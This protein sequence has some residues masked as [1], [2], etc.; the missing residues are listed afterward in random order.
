MGK[1]VFYTGGCAEPKGAVAVNRLEDVDKAEYLTTDE[2]GVS[3]FKEIMFIESST[4]ADWHIRRFFD[5]DLDDIDTDFYDYFILD[6]VSDFAYKLVDREQTFGDADYFMERIK[7]DLNHLIEK[8][9]EQAEMLIILSDDVGC[10]VRPSIKTDRL[11]QEVIG[12]INRYIA[13][14]ADEVN[15]VECGIVRRI[16]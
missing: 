14:V 13:D 4:D 9:R 2:L 5:L 16:K 3:A 8:V 7:A 6:S 11:A 10:S 15:I 1:I 12:N